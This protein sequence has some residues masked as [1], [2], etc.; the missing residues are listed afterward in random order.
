MAGRDLDA[1][2]HPAGS[3]DV[4]DYPADELARFVDLVRSSPEIAPTQLSTV[5]ALVRVI[6]LGNRLRQRQADLA[7]GIGLILSELDILY[8]LQRS[9]VPLRMTDL[10]T[11]LGGTQGGLSKRIDRLVRDGLV[12]REDDAQDRRIAWL[13]LSPMGANRVRQARGQHLGW[14]AQ[15]LTDGEWAMLDDMLRRVTQAIDLADQTAARDNAQP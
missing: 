2:R 9:T 11:M 8:L 4:Q 10:L 12:T 15:A 1:E 14:G 5:V 6:R 3:P 7:A 13:S